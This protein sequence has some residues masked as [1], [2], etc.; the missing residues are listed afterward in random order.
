MGHIVMDDRRLAKRIT[1]PS[2]RYCSL[3]NEISNGHAGLY[4]RDG[5]HLNPAGH[6][7]GARCLEPFVKPIARQARHVAGALTC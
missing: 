6:V 3:M 7:H 5:L 2:A 1:P 4:P